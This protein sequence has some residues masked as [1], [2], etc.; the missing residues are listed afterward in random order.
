MTI[1]KGEPWGSSVERPPGLM[2]AGSDRQLASLVADRL[3]QPLGVSNGDVYRSIGAPGERSEL[4]RLPMDLLRVEADGRRLCAV[5]HV[6]VRRSWWYGGIVAVMNV[7][8]VGEWNVAPRAHPNDGRFDVLEVDP[9]M[10]VRQR[11]QARG[12]L[13][14]GTHVPHPKIATRTGTRSDWTFERAQRL[15]LDGE[16]VGSVRVLSVEVEADAF[17]IHV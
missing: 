1:R 8:H 4:V 12:R 15:W 7:D 9:A 10:T 2:V 11:L 13:V 17:A 16:Q 5:A 6:V 14:Q 3:G